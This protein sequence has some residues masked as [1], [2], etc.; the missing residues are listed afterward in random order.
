MYVF[1]K[2]CVIGLFMVLIPAFALDNTLQ[3][4]FWDTRAYINPSPAVEES[5]VAEKFDSGVFVR[6]E[7]AVMEFF[8]SVKRGLIFWI[9]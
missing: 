4:D 2:V 5:A 7:S 6:V 9:R 3:N 1:K 8:S